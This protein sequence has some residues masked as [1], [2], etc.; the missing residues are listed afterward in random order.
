MADPLPIFAPELA[1]GNDSFEAA[2]FELL[3]QAE[4]GSFWF[5]NRNQLIF[6]ALAR[7]FPDARSFFEI[8]VGTGF[9]LSGLRRE[10]PDLELSGAD[11][12]TEGIKIA[13]ARLPGVSLY[14]MDCL[15]IPFR[16][17]FDVV[18]AFDVLEHIDGDQAA[19]SE[20]FK[21]TRPGGGVMLSVPQHRWLWSQA[22]EYAHHR[23]RY[24][25]GELLGR[26][27]EAGFEVLQATGFVS[28][29]L[30]AMAL[31][32]LRKR[33]EASAGWKALEFDLPPRIDRGLESLLKVENRL[34]A[35]GFSFPVGGSLLAVGKRTG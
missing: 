28:L 30:P 26:M 27:R 2:S 21:A 14:Q 9:V 35:R 16:E 8:G 19:L 13:A 34:I 1:A 17:E 24:R 7:H 23:R 5:R 11:I 25:R 15:R 18:A 4:H 3:A 29:P 31:S 12:F 6:Q 10:F 33:T 32:R 20:L 22:D